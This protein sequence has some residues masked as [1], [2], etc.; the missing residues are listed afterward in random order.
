MS[1]TAIP[2]IRPKGQ[3]TNEALPDLEAALAKHALTKGPGVVLDLVYVDF[4]ASAGLAVLVKFGMRLHGQERRIAMAR[5][6]RSVEK[7]I[8]LLGLDVR[9]P[10][11]R[12]V[13]E[14]T[15]FVATP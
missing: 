13:E 5:A 11:Y 9:M 7:T 10:L 4:I 12:T 2:V 6:E 14:A 3:I 1:D 8:R 15:V